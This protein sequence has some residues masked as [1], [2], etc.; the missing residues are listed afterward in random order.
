METKLFSW[1]GKNLNLSN[2]LIIALGILLLTQRCEHQTQLRDFEKNL[3][4]REAVIEERI[5]SLGEKVLMVSSDAF[6]N[7]E[8]KILQRLDST[9]KALDI[10]LAANGRKIKDLHSSTAFTV[11]SGNGGIAVR[12][13]T[14]Y[15]KSSELYIPSIPGWKYSDGTISITSELL[16]DSSLLQ[17]Y[18]IHPINFRVDTFV[19]NRPLKKPQFFADITSTNSSIQFSNAS[20]AIKKY[21]KAFLSLGLGVGGTLTK[22]LKIH[23]G[24]QLGIYKPIYTIYR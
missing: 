10:R 2:V 8:L 5:N 17:A 24:L 13:D 11:E 4:D 18:N 21:P 23:P 22:D 9:Y 12:V 7:S 14:V 6:R 16:K 3:N 19:K 1:L 20:V 15:R